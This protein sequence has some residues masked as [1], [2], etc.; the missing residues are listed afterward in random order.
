MYHFLTGAC[1][2]TS[3]G[4]I[5]PPQHIRKAYHQLKMSE[6]DNQ[7]PHVE[8]GV[9]ARIAK[10]PICGYLWTGLRDEGVCPECGIRFDERSTMWRGRYFYRF[11]M[12]MFLLVEMFV[13]IFSGLGI[14]IPVEANKVILVKGG[15]IFVVACLITALLNSQERLAPRLLLLSDRIVIFKWF[16]SRTDII[17]L[18]SIQQM[19]HSIGVTGRPGL[20][21]KLKNK[22]EVRLTGW[23]RKEISEIIHKIGDQ[24]NN[25]TNRNTSGDTT[26][27]T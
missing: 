10:C 16:G 4:P 17:E 18:F 24:I 3:L 23:K 15:G 27:E 9:S 7:S 11:I 5:N 22:S 13:I 25:I 1:R 2:T 21:I 6:Q 8:K 20:V 19:N 26:W 14:F 12:G